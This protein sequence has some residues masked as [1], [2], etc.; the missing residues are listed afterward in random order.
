MVDH[1]GSLDRARSLFPG[2]PEPWV[3]LST[4]IN[5]HSYPYRSISATAFTRLPEPETAAT[6]KAEAAVCYRAGSEKTVVAA[7]GTQMLL[8]L[9]MSLV[10]PGRAAVLSPTYAEHARTARLAGHVV[11]EVSDVAELGDA[12]LAVVV[13]PNNPD[14][15]I[16]SRDALLELAAKLA[17]KGGLLV[18]DE[19]FMDVAPAEHSL[20]GDVED[21]PLVVLRSFGKFFGLAGIRLGF[22]IASEGIAGR[23]DAQLGPWAV[24]G[25]A[26][27]IG[28]Q[29][30]RDAAWQS[31]MRERLEV[32][33]QRLADLI[34]R[35]KPSASGGTT[36]FRFMRHPEARRIFD[37][38]GRQGI[39]V[40]AFDRDPE[41]LRFGLPGS[42]AEWT[43][44]EAAL[45]LWLH[46]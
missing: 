2:A 15:R 18:V 13:N 11:H 29:G 12:N 21:A 20:A 9:V 45:A 43:R 36:L 28:L 3:D 8:P 27:E 10:P 44:V 23:L 31:A 25:L 1:G 5:P 42:E 22:A 26:V 19:A 32:E 6:L 30:L 7:P 24:S 4:G 39:L 40:R 38:L 37:T 16:I 33:S 41:A 14:G 17:R 34:Q 35:S 46:R